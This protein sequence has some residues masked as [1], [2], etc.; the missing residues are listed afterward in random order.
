MAGSITMFSAILYTCGFIK[1]V[2]ENLHT[3]KGV[4]S[5]EFLP[6]KINRTH[7]LTHPDDEYYTQ[8]KSHVKQFE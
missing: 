7:D 2:K 5:S 6:N 8:R 1:D 3:S 4:T